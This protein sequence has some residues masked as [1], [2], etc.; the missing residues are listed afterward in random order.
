MNA[1]VDVALIAGFIGM[2]V[3]VLVQ[4]Y[5]HHHAMFQAAVAQATPKKQTNRKRTG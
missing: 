3:D 5:G 1:G 2:S 4:V